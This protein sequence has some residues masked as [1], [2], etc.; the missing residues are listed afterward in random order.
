MWPTHTKK[1]MLN[2]PRA[3]HDLKTHVFCSS[4]RSFRFH[5]ENLTRSS[6][7]RLLPSR[8]EHRSARPRLSPS[9][10]FRIKASL[11]KSTACATFSILVQSALMPTPVKVRLASSRRQTKDP[12]S[13]VGGVFW[14][15]KICRAKT[16]LPAA[17]WNVAGR[18]LCA[19]LSAISH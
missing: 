3:N 18:F 7:K 15:Y 5:L 1:G 19:P 4:E 6:L 9:G 14:P 13:S 11:A 8:W 10:T 2:N 12:G 17:S 16:N